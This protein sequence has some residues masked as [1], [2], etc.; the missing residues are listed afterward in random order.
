MLY[1]EVLKDGLEVLG[2]SFYIIP[3]SIHEVLLLKV[4]Q[5]NTP[6]E[7]AEFI[8]ATNDNVLDKDDILSYKLYFYD[9]ES[10]E[11]SIAA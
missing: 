11:V 5:R 10:K 9:K 2:D 1:P 4:D 3:S 7:L 8:K 6:K